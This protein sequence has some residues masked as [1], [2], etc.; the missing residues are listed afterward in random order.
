M[1]SKPREWPCP[2]GDGRTAER[3]MDI[4]NPFLSA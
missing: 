3:V 1:M 4:L 2:F